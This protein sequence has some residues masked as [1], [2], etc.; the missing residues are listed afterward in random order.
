MCNKLS[1][2]VGDGNM[3]ESFEWRLTR[4]TDGEETWWI[5]HPQELQCVK[6]LAPLFL[7]YA[8]SFFLSL[9][10]IQWLIYSNSKQ[11]FC[12]LKYLFRIVISL[13]LLRHFAI[14]WCSGYLSVKQH[15]YAEFLYLHVF[16]S[17]IYYI[18]LIYSDAKIY[19]LQLHNLSRRPRLL[20]IS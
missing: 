1:K 12:S 3:I 7:V 2:Y 15:K 11:F 13:M 8:V 16:L 5:I 9:S 19:V 4:F 6:C 20:C 18:L 14:N 17:H 10:H